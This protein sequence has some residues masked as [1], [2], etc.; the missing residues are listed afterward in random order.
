MADDEAD[1]GDEV[2]Q[3]QREPHHHRHRPA[4]PGTGPGAVQQPGHGDHQDLGADQDQTE[5][6]LFT[7]EWNTVKLSSQCPSPL[8]T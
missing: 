1:G 6:I 4:D 3:G 5:D 8:G 2:R 7:R